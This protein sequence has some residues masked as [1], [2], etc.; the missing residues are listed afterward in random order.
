M[1]IRMRVY[2]QNGAL[3]MNGLNGMNGGAVSVA[4][5]FNSKLQAQ[6]Q[7]GN[8]EL[9]Y[10]KALANE[11]IENAR[12]EE[13]LK[14]PYLA[15]GMGMAGGAFGG[16][17]GAY[18]GMPLGLGGVPMAGG[19]PIGINPL[20]M[21]MG[22]MPMMGG[23][24]QGFG[25]SGQTNITNQTSTGSGNQTV[26]NSNTFQNANTTSNPYGN[27]WGMPRFGGGGFLSG[28]LGALI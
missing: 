15:G 1:A 9:G 3:G 25:G 12:L 26:S 21:G 8:L 4:T 14:N 5:H 24:P 2:P 28:L 27:G 10:V 23:I 17:A 11:K 6:K 13:R 16:M 22:Q 18:G 7:I 20:A 19:M